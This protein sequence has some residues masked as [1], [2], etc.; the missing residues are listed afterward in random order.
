MWKRCLSGSQSRSARHRIVSTRS[1]AAG[2]PR[3]CRATTHSPLRVTASASSSSAAARQAPASMGEEDL[4][5]KF[6]IGDAHCHP[7]DDPAACAA[8]LGSLSAR[9]LAV[10]GTRADDW[11]A[12]EQLS[13][14]EPG[15]VIPC[16]GVHPWFA[17]RHALESDQVA[18]PASLMDTPPNGKD[19]PSR[20]PELMSGPPPTAP[21]T[22]LPRLRGLLRAHPHSVVGEFGLDRAA[23]VPGTRLQPSWSHQLALTELHLR[24][25]SELR[26]PASLHCVQGYGH[27]QDMLRRL[28]PEGC[29]PKIMLHSYGGSVDLIKGFTKLPGGVGDRIYFSFSSVINGR[30]GRTKLL[31][32]LAAVPVGRLLLESDQCSPTRVDAGLRDILEAAA[33]ARGVGL[34]QAAEEAAEAFRD[35]YADSLAHMT[36]EGTVAAAGGAVTAAAAPAVAAE[37]EE[38]EVEGSRRQEGG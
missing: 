35:F 25:A 1:T 34:E 13:R 31:Q 16:F 4:L 38:A 9:Y 19:D 2:K 8:G 23:V 37:E 20:H 24:L 30:Q 26:R 33:E 10:M 5:V 7:Q 14:R 29:P 22:W 12:V 21:E 3:S 17:H 15:K 6:G 28:G 18:H 11:E 32:R 27:L 36:R